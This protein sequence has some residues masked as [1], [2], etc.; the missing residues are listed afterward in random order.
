MRMQ[1][2]LAGVPA[3][4]AQA[5]RFAI[6]ALG[7]L[8]G[9]IV[10]DVA[11]MVS[12]LATNALVHAATSFTVSV[13]RRERMV[14][15]E[16][17]DVG[18]GIPTRRSPGETEAHGRGLAIV[19]ELSDQWGTSHPAGDI[20]KSVWFTINMPVEHQTSDAYI[21]RRDLQPDAS[22]ITAAMG[23]D[24]GAGFGPL[25]RAQ[26]SMPPPRDRA[27][28]DRSGRGWASIS[29]GPSSYRRKSRRHSQ[30]VE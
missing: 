10:N 22:M 27:P 21:A 18:S 28:R 14:H 29:E 8:P 20:G 3:S 25:D 17:T 13:D 9:D 1:R 4:V 5:R 15:V 7:D 2:H 24:L 6:E 16:V 19:E 11:V 23:D 26:G 30:M 12:E